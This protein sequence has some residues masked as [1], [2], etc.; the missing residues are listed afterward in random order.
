[1]D[2][3]S[4]RIRGV[5]RTIVSSMRDGIRDKE[6]Q[7]AAC[8]QFLAI[9]DDSADPGKVRAAIVKEDGIDAIVT[10]MSR[11]M[12]EFQMPAAGCRALARIAEDSPEAKE[13]LTENDGIDVVLRVMSR[14][15]GEYEV[16]ESGASMLATVADKASLD[17][18]EILATKG[19]VSVVMLAMVYHEKLKPTGMKLLTTMDPSEVSAA[20]EMLCKEKGTD[21]VEKPLQEIQNEVWKQ[22]G[23]A[24]SRL[25][26][27]NV[28]SFGC[29]K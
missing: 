28:F 26:V 5:I 22:N 21:R 25:C 8:N 3:S 17:R 12:S 24:F 15:P 1:M 16:Q 7:E 23:S 4:S 18:R 11:H 6:V 13:A 2:Q 20:R 14:Y 19:A 9:L 10:A 27:C 29:G